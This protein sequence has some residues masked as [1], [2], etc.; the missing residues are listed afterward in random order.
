MNS[1]DEEGSETP[2]VDTTDDMDAQSIR[3]LIQKSSRLD[4]E[5]PDLLGRA[6][7]FPTLRAARESAPHFDVPDHQPLDVGHGVCSLRG[8]APFGG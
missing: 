3:A 5:A 7:R 2:P 8:D 6:V 4:H 1:G